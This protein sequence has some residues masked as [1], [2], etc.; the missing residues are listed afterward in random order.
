MLLK[1]VVG[2]WKQARKELCSSGNK[3]AAMEGFSVG[4]QAGKTEGLLEG[5]EVYL[6]SDEHK[7]EVVHLKGFD[8]GFDQSRLDLS[9][10]ANFQPY[11]EEEATVAEPNGFNVLVDEVAKLS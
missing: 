7:R 1:E 10:D 2:W 4:G 3:V 5:H 6:Q 11:P 8:E 9:L